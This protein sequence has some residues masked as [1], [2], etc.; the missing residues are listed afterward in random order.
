MEKDALVNIVC[1]DGKPRKWCN[2]I[3][4]FQEITG[5]SKKYYCSPNPCSITE[6]D[7]RVFTA[8]KSEIRI[9]D[10]SKAEA[11]LGTHYRIPNEYIFS[12]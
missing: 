3:R 11:R 12:L 10:L 4:S 7:N 2:I 6:L 8:D 1:G 5:E 9:A